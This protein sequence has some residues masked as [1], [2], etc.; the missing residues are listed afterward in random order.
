MTFAKLK[1][2]KNDEIE[3]SIFGPGKGECVVLHLGNNDWIIVDSCVNRASKKPIALEYLESLGISPDEAVKLVAVSHWHDD[4]I[5]GTSQIVRTCKDAYFVCANA[6]L[7]SEFAQFVEVYSKRFR[8]ERYDSGTDEFAAI[9]EQLFSE[10]VGKRPYP[11]R[12]LWAAANKRLA[13]WDGGGR[14]FPVELYS[15]SP[16]D[17]AFSLAIAEFRDLL[18]QPGTPKRRAPSLSPNHA[19]AAFWIIAGTFN[20]LL[21]GDLETGSNEDL[22]WRA[23]MGS[24]ARPSGRASIVKA[25]HH[26]AQSGYYAP[27]WQQMA[28]PNTVS[29]IAPFCG[30][31]KPLP[32][33][34]DIARIKKHTQRIFITGEPK[35]WSPK[36]RD[37]AADKFSSTVVLTRRRVEGEMGHVCVRIPQGGKEMQIHLS[38]GAQSL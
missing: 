27:M 17:A 13:V 21:G 20:I 38:S 16:S 24:A 30:G 15:L 19:S 9:T 26:G 31:V 29:L 8:S 5:K 33:E 3:V 12:L 36:R 1:A 22:G 32:S 23:V 25:P 35:G 10:Y 2:P 7:R 18:P 37:S 4:H 6:L 34:K 11:K 28:E 14:P